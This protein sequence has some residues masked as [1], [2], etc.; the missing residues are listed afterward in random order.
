[1]SKNNNLETEKFHRNCDPHDASHCDIN[2]HHNLEPG[3]D[4]CGHYVNAGPGVGI[5]VGGGHAINGV[6]SAGAT[7]GSAKGNHDQDPKH[8]PGVK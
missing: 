2:N 7:P 5:P 8:G 6:I 1:M 4:D 3:A